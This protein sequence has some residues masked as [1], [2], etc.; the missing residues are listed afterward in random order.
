MPWYAQLQILKNWRYF[1]L[2]IHPSIFLFQILQLGN[3]RPCS[4][5]DFFNM[6][7]LCPMWECIYNY[8]SY[9]HPFW[10]QAAPCRK[11]L[12][13]RLPPLRSRAR[14]SFTPLWVLWC[15]KWCL[16][17]FSSWFLPFSPAT[18]FILPFFPHPFH[19]I[20][21][22]LAMVRQAWSA[23]ILANRRPSVKG[24]HRISSL[25]LA[26]CWTRVEDIIFYSNLTSC[27][28]MPP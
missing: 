12:D 24:H 27:E 9:R 26:L 20:S 17:R 3:R 7:L 22:A 10:F 18:N 25:D 15:T 4:E 1:T 5:N 13:T 6:S 21:S 8:C 19:F 16:G 2:E 11:R 23:G 28:C 14:V